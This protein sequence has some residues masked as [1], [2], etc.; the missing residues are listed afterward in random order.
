MLCTFPWTFVVMH[1]PD[2]ILSRHI[3]A[4]RRGKPTRGQSGIPISRR[5]GLEGQ[6]LLWLGEYESS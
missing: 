1:N 4:I 5:G 3:G 6:L 2:V